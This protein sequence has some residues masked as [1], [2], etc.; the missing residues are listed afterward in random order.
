MSK[1]SKKPNLMGVYIRVLKYVGPYKRRVAIVVI[2]SILVGLLFSG[3]LLMVKP[4][5]EIVFET[6]GL[7]TVPEPSEQ[8]DPGDMVGEKV[9]SLPVVQSLI[10]W[11]DETI[12]TPFVQTA[13]ADAVKALKIVALALFLMTVARGLIEYCQDYLG[14]WVAHRI[15]MDMS[16]QM[17]D[18][19]LDLSFDF[20]HEGRVGETISRFSA[21][22]GMV[23]RGVSSFFSR[24]IADP[25]KMI[26]CLGAA[27]YLNPKLC[28]IA[29][30]GTPFAA[31]GIG[32]I[33]R[34]IQKYSRRVLVRQAGLM[35]NMQEKFL[36][37]QVIKAFVTEEREKSLFRDLTENLFRTNLHVA[38]ARSATGPILSVCTVIGI[39]VFIVIGGAMVLDENAGWETADFWTFCALLAGTFAPLR[40]LSKAYNAMVM[41]AV[42]GSRIF[43]YMDQEPTIQD[44]PGAEKI[45]PIAESIRLENVSF[46]YD[47]K[48]EVL[49]DINFTARKGQITALVGPSGAGKTTLV[50]LLPRFYDVESGSITIDGSDIREATL[51][52]L[53]GQIG[54]VTQDTMLFNLP[55]QDNIRYAKPEATLEEVEY[56]ARAANADGFIEQLPGGYESIVGE[57]GENLSG[58]QCQRIAIA[59]AI[60]KNPSI[61]ILDE[62]TSNLDS[63]S[64]QAIHKALDEFMKDR[65]TFVIAHRLSTVLR[66]DQILVMNEGRIVERGTHQELLA[67][68]GLYNRLYTTQF[69]SFDEPEEA[70]KDEASR[71]PSTWVGIPARYGSKRFPGKCLARIGEKSI[72]QHV[73][74][75]VSKAEGIDGV[76][77]ATDDA[78][79]QTACEEFGA[80]VVMTSPD[81]PSGT[82]RLAEAIRSVA[83]DVL[84]NVQGDEPLIEPEL[85]S[86]LADLMRKNPQVRMATVASPIQ[87]PEEI[88]NPNTVKVVLDGN[89]DAVYFSRSALPSG[90][91]ESGKMR[92]Y[93]HIGM[94]AY[95]ADVL[96]RLS[97]APPSNLEEGERLEQLRTL[98]LGIKIRVLIGHS[99]SIGV[100]TPE[101]LER[102]RELLEQKTQASQRV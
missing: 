58:G 88:E 39:T 29:I 66:A 19:V 81:H 68:G 79:I 24:I 3:S 82:D 102:A 52:S 65:T 37:I 12:R 20:F 56:A 97:H 18:K 43:E 14:R 35:A 2:C 1:K 25:M 6:A 98:D 8:S 49:S 13:E 17:Y 77:I 5:V 33:R 44:K 83:A 4:I 63:E 86:G 50:S 90:R 16:N 48:T 80:K 93:R 22:V 67:K 38:R 10:S 75:Q 36:G 73:W 26:F 21:D 32:Q 92:Y 89:G 54:I 7:E 87:H 72:I 59:R 74:E 30:L 45:D 69:A 99:E 40:S 95:R 76:L 11:F 15:M 94:Y 53:R 27:F 23:N 42:A 96:E 64:E 28:L 9:R 47:G 34:K 101:D 61:L 85:V 51:K 100:D 31:I 55:V 60:L 57:R 91:D 78:R 46:N 41:S 62:A 84:I 71:T 70:K